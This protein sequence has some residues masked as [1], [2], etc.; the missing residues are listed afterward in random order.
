MTFHFKT[1]ASLERVG[2]GGAAA[3]LAIS[4]ASLAGCG[5]VSGGSTDA[6]R[7]RAID[8]AV[9]AGTANVLVNGASANG[10]QQALTQTETSPYLYISG[11]RQSSFSFN[12]S[13]TAPSDVLVPTTPNLTLR[14]GQFYSAFLIGRV[15]V[16]P[17]KTAPGTKSVNDP[18]FLQ[19]VVTNDAHDA[20]ANGSA[21]VRVVDAAPDGGAVD[22]A[23]N[24]QTLAGYGGLT[25]QEPTGD[26]LPAPYV[27]VP[28]GTLS[29]QANHAGTTTSLFPPVSVPVS[30]GKTYTLI[31][32]QPTVGTTAT[33]AGGTTTAPTFGLQT[34]QDNG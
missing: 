6:A 26:F 27:N 24:G 18:R 22:V 10:D 14:N 2:R 16:S 23:V 13:V 4:A 21:L 1:R 20:P 32:T 9:N 31:L 17:A 19:V 30:A 29:V 15:D 7:V 3:L 5:G 8:A 11:D 28:A 25:F 34:I 33:A 12:T